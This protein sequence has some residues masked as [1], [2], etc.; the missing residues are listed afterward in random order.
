MPSSRR[1]DAATH[2]AI[3]K[4]MSATYRRIR[5]VIVR[6]PR[7]CVMTYGDVAAAA[8]M[9]RAARVV[10]YALHAIGG[11]V[12]WQR[13]VGRKSDHLAKVSIKNPV[14]GAMQRKLLEKEGVVFTRTGAIDL[15]EHGWG[16]PPRPRKAKKPA[17]PTKST[18]RPTRK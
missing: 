2:E 14:G 11:Q 8:G 1:T 9:P 7:G 17:K 6:I 13:V 4:H 15:D 12:P 5:D 10:G 18:K 3:T 16:A